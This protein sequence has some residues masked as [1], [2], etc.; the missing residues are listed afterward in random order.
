MAKLEDIVNK[1]KDGAKFVITSAML[2]LTTTEFD[3]LAQI[4]IKNGGP[5]FTMSGVPFRKCIDGEFLIDRVT[6]IKCV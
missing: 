5:G 2:R 6:V 1:Q 3:S 4:W